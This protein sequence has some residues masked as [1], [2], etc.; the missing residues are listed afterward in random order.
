MPVELALD[1]D[2]RERREVRGVL[3]SRSVEEKI[4]LTRSWVAHALPWIVGGKVRPIVDRCYPLS[5]AAEAHGYLESNRSFG[6]V[7][8]SVAG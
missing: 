7:V 4:A 2:R 1:G 6:K 5:E 8:L 3:R